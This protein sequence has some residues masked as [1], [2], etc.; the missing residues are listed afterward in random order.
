VQLACSLKEHPPQL[1]PENLNVKFSTIS[2]FQLRFRE[3][4]R[5]SNWSRNRRPC[6]TTPAL[7]LHIQLLHLRDRLRPATQT[8]DETVGLHKQII[9]AQTVRKHLREAHLGACH[10]HQCL[11]L[12]AVQHCNRLQWENAHLQW[13][14]GRKA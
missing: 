8:A 10:P 9:S 6:V 12:T 11:N 5:T 7:D 2:R 14:L 4:V 1:L 13:L 3:C